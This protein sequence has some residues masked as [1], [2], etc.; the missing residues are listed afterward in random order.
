[1]LKPTYGKAGEKPSRAREEGN[2]PWHWHTKQRMMMKAEV[3]DA[4]KIRKWV[5]VMLAD[6]GVMGAFGAMMF[7]RWLVYLW[8]SRRILVL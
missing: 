4:F 2:E 3:S 7:V 1:M 8:K 5:L 6:A